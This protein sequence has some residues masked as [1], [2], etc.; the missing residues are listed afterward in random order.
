MGARWRGRP[1]GWGPE[2]WE[3]PK[4]RVFFPFPP[5]RSFFFSLWGSSR[6]IL[7]VF[8]EGGDPQMCALGVLGLLCELPAAHSTR[9]P[10]EREKERNGGGRGKKRNVGGPAEERSDGEKK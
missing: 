5:F 1:I 8:F 4:F 6:G 3:S 7:V 9:R 10:P 2:G